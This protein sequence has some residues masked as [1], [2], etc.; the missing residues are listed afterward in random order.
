M[1]PDEPVATTRTLGARLGV[2]AWHAGVALLAAALIWAVMLVIVHTFGPELF[3]LTFVV[4]AL[5]T[6]FG[7]VDRWLD[8]KLER[9][10]R[11]L[12][13]YKESP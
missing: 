8:V 2:L 11:R 10:A 6:W 4:V 3:A 9:L 7:I 13:G 12:T 1:I 5:V